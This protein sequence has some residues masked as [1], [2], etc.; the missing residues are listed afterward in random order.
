MTVHEKM[1]VE[2]ETVTCNLQTSVSY[3]QFNFNNIQF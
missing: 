3:Q 1:R 2:S